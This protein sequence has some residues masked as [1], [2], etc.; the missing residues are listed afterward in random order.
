MDILILQIVIAALAY[1]LLVP[2]AEFVGDMI[3]LGIKKLLK[4]R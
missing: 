2:V 3:R 4:V 1:K